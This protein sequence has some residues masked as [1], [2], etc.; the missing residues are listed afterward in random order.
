MRTIAAMLKQI[1]THL[2]GGPLGAGKTSLIRQLLTQKPADERWAVL[3]NEFGQI[4]LDAA[5]LGPDTDGVTMAEIPGG[6]LCCVNGLPFQVGLARLLRKA[7][8]DRLLIEPSGL[9]HPAELLRQLRQPP[10]QRVLAVQPSVLVLDAA[11]LHR[12]E[13]LP[14]SQRQALPD[15]GLLLLNKSEGLDDPSR[16]ALARQLPERPLYWT[17][18]GQLPIDRLP[19]IGAR[20]SESG[21]PIS[22]PN[23]TPAL[24]Q[25]WFDT[26]KAICQVQATPHAWSI[27]WRWHPSQRLDLDRIAQWLAQW[28]WQRAK[29]VIHG[30]NGW[31]SANAVEGQA[32]AFRPSEWRRD[33][34][35][36]LIF[37]EPQDQ[38]ELERGLQ[39][40]RIAD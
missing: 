21:Q 14:D 30:G 31:Q 32:L 26:S 24:N 7:R 10:W 6:C 11:A 33:S 4:G 37:S 35:L 40:C 3:V 16:Q 22:L 23:G 5:L 38:L 9:G 39:A 2:V 28:P 20:A 12:G 13:A 27:G 29:L 8:P 17:T 34:R 19:G 18:H 36:E 15:A 25:V 1:P